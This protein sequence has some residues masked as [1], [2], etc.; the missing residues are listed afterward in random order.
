MIQ[1]AK[2]RSM[3]LRPRRQVLVTIQEACTMFILWTIPPG[4]SF[5]YAGG[6][7]GRTCKTPAPLEE[8]FTRRG[9]NMN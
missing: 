3:L 1:L 6:L 5:A 2:R 8:S 4:R 7:M 9:N